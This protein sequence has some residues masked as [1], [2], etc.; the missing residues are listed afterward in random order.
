VIDLVS[1]DPIVGSH[2]LGSVFS[3]RANSPGVLRL[4]PCNTFIVIELVER[5]GLFSVELES[6]FVVSQPEC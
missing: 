1:T 4:R 2:G 3:P 6:A 5:H